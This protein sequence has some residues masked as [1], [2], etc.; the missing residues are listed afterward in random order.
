M[1]LQARKALNDLNVSMAGRVLVVGSSV[2]LALLEDDRIS[3]AQNSGDVIAADALQEARLPRVGG[4]TI[5]GSN[6]LGED[7]AY[8]FHQTAIA[9][10][11]FAPAIPAG[12]SDGAQV[13]EEG[14]GLRYL[15]DYNPTNST[16]PVDR[17]LVDAFAGAASVEQDGENKRLVAINFTAES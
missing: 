5:V 17:S 12:A 3:K 4:F 11:A 2:E 15:R 13:S 10:G 6:A 1:V 8:A 7:E 9:F 14:L 16:G